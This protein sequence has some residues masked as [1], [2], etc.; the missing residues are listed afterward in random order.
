MS[1]NI[2]IL[3][4]ATSLKIQPLILLNFF[5]MTPIIVTVIA[6]Y[7]KIVLD[8]MEEVETEVEMEVLTAQLIVQI[9]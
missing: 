4:S 8:Q 1:L 6:L 7:M 5:P 9:F 3:E 2:A